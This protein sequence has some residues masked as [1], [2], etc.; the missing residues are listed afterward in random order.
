MKANNGLPSYEQARFVCPESPEK[1]IY[2]NLAAAQRGAKRARD[3]YGVKQLP[4]PCSGCGQYHLTSDRK[5]GDIAFIGTDGT[6]KT[7]STHTSPIVHIYPERRDMTE[8]LAN[9][10]PIIHNVHT[11]A[12]ILREWGKDKPSFRSKDAAEALGGATPSQTRDAL[13]EAGFLVVGRAKAAL[14]FKAGD[15]IPDYDIVQQRANRI[16][17]WAK[18]LDSFSTTDVLE[19]Q[20]DIPPAVLREALHRGGFISTGATTGALWYHE[21]KPKPQVNLEAIQKHRVEQLEKGRETARKNRENAAKLAAEREAKAAKADAKAAA[22][23]K[24]R[25]DLAAANEELAAKAA[26]EK[27]RLEDEQTRLAEERTRLEEE[28]AAARAELEQARD[29]AA[30]ANLEQARAQAAVVPTVV[31]PPAHERVIFANVPMAADVPTELVDGWED[32]QVDRMKHLP[33]ADVLEILDAAGLEVSFRTRRKA[34]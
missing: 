12:K 11:R 18:D 25:D 15:P 26:E 17:E 16:T 2:A 5:G 1:L 32:A 19:A 21:S 4:Y 6:L 9:E 24:A 23:A 22:A 34:R 7:R 8:V 13:V 20:G 33:F 28:V 10:K 14:W 31:N 3:K 30:R 29:D 27:A